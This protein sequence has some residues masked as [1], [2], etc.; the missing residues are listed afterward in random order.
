M[1]VQLEFRPRTAHLTSVHF[2]NT[3]LQEIQQTL[4]EKLSASPEGFFSGMGFI[5]NLEGLS[6]EKA[7]FNWLKE[8]KTIF[9][10]NGL[11]LIALTHHPYPIKTLTQLGL[12]DIPMKEARSTKKET[13]EVSNTIT[14]PKSTNQEPSS[15]LASLSKN[16]KLDTKIIRGNIRSGQRVYAPDTDLTIIGIV[17]AGAEVIADGNIHIL[18]SLRGRAF[19]GAKGNESTYIYASDFSAELVSIAGSYQTMEQLDPYKGEKN[20]LVT[21]NEDDT[22]LIVSV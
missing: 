15:P 3:N 8:L 21:L 1:S 6:I 16:S 14:E 5:A 20:C 18:G 22:M 9:L 11:T 12:A 2:S 19:S 10:D 7:N 13:L 17:G 4:K